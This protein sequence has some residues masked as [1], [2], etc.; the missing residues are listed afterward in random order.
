VKLPAPGIQLPRPTGKVALLQVFNKGLPCGWLGKS[1]QGFWFHYNSGASTQSWLCL[2]MPPTQNHYQQQHLFPVFQQHLPTP[3]GCEWLQQHMPNTPL[4]ELELL[5]MA[6]ANTLG[7][8]SFSNPD[9]PVVQPR[10]H[11]TTQRLQ[12]IARDQTNTLGTPLLQGFSGEQHSTFL[13]G[14][15]A[16]NN[17]PNL[18]VH[19]LQNTRSVQELQNE[20]L[21]IKARA[22]PSNKLQGLRW[23]STIQ[24]GNALWFH[25]RPDLEPF[26]QQRLGMDNIETLLNLN[27]LQ[28][29]E[30]LAHPARFRLV[31]HEVIRTYCKHA[32]E[33][34]KLLDALFDWI[35]QGTLKPCVVYEPRPTVLGMNYLWASGLP[36]QG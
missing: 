14:N 21:K 19:L 22:D 28:Y 31:C 10:M 34:I 36:P 3:Q 18:L 29:R 17:A 2:T 13:V 9:A 23:A 5:A 7:S 25:N 4:G 35:V 12:H 32:Q 26:Q 16:R 8:L 27:P 15:Q 11:T 1:A 6:G 30:L 24:T 20:L 33:E